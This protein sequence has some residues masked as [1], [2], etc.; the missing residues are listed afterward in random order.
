M[1]SDL[2]QPDHEVW[3]Q[4]IRDYIENELAPHAEEW[5]EAG[6]VPREIFKQMGKLGYL[7]EIPRGVR[8]R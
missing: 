2:F 5:E 3:R 6:E 4:T 7:D 1:S 8:R